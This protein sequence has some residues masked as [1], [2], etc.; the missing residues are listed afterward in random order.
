MLVVFRTPTSSLSSDPPLSWKRFNMRQSQRAFI[1]LRNLVIPTLALGVCP[2]LLLC[3]PAVRLDDN[4]RYGRVGHA[5]SAR[6]SIGQCS[7]S[8]TKVL[9]HGRT[10]SWE[11]TPGN[12]PHART[13]RRTDALKQ[14]LLPSCTDHERI[15]PVK[16][17]H[18]F[19]R[20][21]DLARD[22]FDDDGELTPTIFE[23]GILLLDKPH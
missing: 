6:R 9:P 7:S 1:R 5:I 18:T 12:T 16:R 15:R 19:N 10:H 21:R 13:E 11:N 8:H 14:I 22:E 2:S 17:D 4:D 3:A 23:V 20:V